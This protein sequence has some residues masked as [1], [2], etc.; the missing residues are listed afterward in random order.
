MGTDHPHLLEIK[1]NSRHGSDGSLEI[2]ADPSEC[3]KKSVD[4]EIKLAKVYGS[5]RI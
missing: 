1:I 4:R 5:F 2:I 3:V